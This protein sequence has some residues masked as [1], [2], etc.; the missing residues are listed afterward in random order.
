MSDDGE[1]KLI[2]GYVSP[3]LKQ[4]LRSLSEVESERAPAVPGSARAGLKSHPYE[5]RAPVKRHDELLRRRRRKEDS[6]Q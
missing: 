3:Y 2:L 1:K 6:V 5:R 4:P